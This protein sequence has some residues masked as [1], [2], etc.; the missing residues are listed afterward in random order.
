MR[1][2]PHTPKKVYAL[3]IA[4]DHR[5]CAGWRNTK[6]HDISSYA[7]YII[8]YMLF[9]RTNLQTDPLDTS[10]RI[11]SMSF[12]CKSGFHPRIPIAQPPPVQQSMIRIFFGDVPKGISASLRRRSDSGN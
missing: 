7:L 8:D 11:Q 2:T 9:N 3:D 10:A 12:G 5:R 6:V 1:E 4:R